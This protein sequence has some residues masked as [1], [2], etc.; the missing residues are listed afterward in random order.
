LEV[1]APVRQ[2]AQAQE[3]AVADFELPQRT[4]RSRTGW[5]GVQLI[6]KLITYNLAAYVHND[7]RY[8]LYLKCN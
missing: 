7:Q 5:I 6:V 8:H 4:K 2:D 1:E 3:S